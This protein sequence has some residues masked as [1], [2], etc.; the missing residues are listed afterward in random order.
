[1]HAASRFIRDR[2]HHPGPQERQSMT[3]DIPDSHVA[4]AWGHEIAQELVDGRSFRM[5]SERPRRVSEVLGLASRW[6][7]RPYVI[8]GE[9]T[10]SFDQ[11]VAAVARK[12]RYLAGLGVSAGDR[13]LVLGWNGPDWVVNFWACQQLLA[14][15]A[16]ANTWWSE[17]EVQE[18]LQLLDP[19]LTLVDRSNAAKVAS[20]WAVGNWETDIDAGTGGE[21]DAGFVR[22]YL[23]TDE[24]DPADI[25]FTSGTSGRAKAV[26]LSHRSRLA[27][28]QM[29]LS[30]TR[31]LPHQVPDD[32]GEVALQTGPL[33]H[34]GGPQMLM[35]SVVVGNTI[36]LPAGRFD[37]GEIIALIARY[38]IVRWSAVPTMVSRVLDHPDVRNTDVSALKALTIGGAPVHPELLERIGRELPGVQAGVPTGYGLTENGG[39][40]TAASGRDTLKH[41]G[42]A[43]RALPLAEIGFEQHPDLPDP[44]ILIRSP[45]Q[46]TRYLG[47]DE[48]PIDDEGWLHTGDL[49]HLDDETRLWIT[50]RAKDLIIRGGENVAPAAVERALTSL[51]GVIEAAVVGIPHAELGEEVCA[52]VVAASGD[53]TGDTLARQLKGR[54]AS[55]AVPTVWRL[56]QDPLPTN[57]TEKVDKRALVASV[58]ADELSLSA[59]HSPTG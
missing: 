31:R 52:F 4:P 36:V 2:R 44:E 51:P 26:E 48:S 18:A 7:A 54:L 53:L 38:R 20:S 42:S 43:G 29:L 34:V 9:R 22:G 14:V 8:Q 39:Q 47:V 16:L 12:A 5:Y 28:L 3:P 1:M 35:R 41:P 19:V 46:M 58:V 6:G 23:D 50:G 24:G 59:D 55:F 37:P 33:F 15:P 32:A 13:V 49:G 30:L 11:L 10:V 40:A 25:V 45:T 56:Q 57:Q 17:T 27:N 21:A